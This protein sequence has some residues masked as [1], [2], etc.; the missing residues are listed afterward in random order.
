MY[1]KIKHKIYTTVVKGGN[2]KQDWN[3]G[4]SRKKIIVQAN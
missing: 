4:Q 3:A 1:D 2:D